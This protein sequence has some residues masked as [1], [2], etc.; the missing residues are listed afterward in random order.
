M[1]A[2]FMGK[3]KRSAVGALEHLLDRG[4]DVAAVVAPE[5]PGLAAPEQRLDLAASR[6]DLPLVADEDLYAAIADPGGARVDLGGV[7]LVLSFLFWKRLRTPLI[8]LG[9]VGCLNFHPAPLPD[10]RG[11]GGYNVAVLE[12]LPEWGVSVH[13]VDESFDTG[14][15]VRV[16]RFE[17]D[18]MHETALS[19][20]IKSQERLLGVFR[21]V[22]DQVASGGALPH[23][24]QGEGRYVAREEFEE[25]RRV[26]PGDPPELTE[27]RMRAFWYPPHDGATIDV[28]RRTLTLVDRHLLEQAAAA[29][30]AAGI[31]P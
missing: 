22:V 3:H 13:F 31:F 6:H 5:Q 24:S 17:I 2:V 11:L 18:P 16:D 1:K 15:I 7:D 29:N 9:S 21:D 19:L 4:W 20:D 12:G 8:E 30:L 26:R 28:G 25:M 23:T 14:D 27:R 10:I